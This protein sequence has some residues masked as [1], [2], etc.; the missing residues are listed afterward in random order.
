MKTRWRPP[1]IGGA[2]GPSRYRAGKRLWNPEEDRALR[3]L[4]P[5]TPTA[6][7]AHQLRR[8]VRALYVRARMLGVEKS[9]AYLASP[10]ACHIR[11]GAAFHPG[12]ATQFKPGQVPANKGVRRPGWL[13]K[14][15]GE[16]TRKDLAF[17][18]RHRVGPFR[19]NA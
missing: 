8:T 6:R 13:P 14:L 9:A 5:D 1:A 2:F 15:A 12:R 10:Y 3:T 19:G 4:Y 16:R 11:R 7:L 17:R 18:K